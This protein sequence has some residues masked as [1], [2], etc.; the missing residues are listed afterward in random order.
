[1]PESEAEEEQTI[2]AYDMKMVL[3][4]NAQIMSQKAAEADALAQVSRSKVFVTSLM[5]VPCA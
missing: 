1:M 4:G 2:P 5:T 3:K